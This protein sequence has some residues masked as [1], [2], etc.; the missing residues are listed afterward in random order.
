MKCKSMNSVILP[1]ICIFWIG[2][3]TVFLQF[4]HYDSQYRLLDPKHY[5]ADV[6]KQEDYKQLSSSKSGSVTL[7]NGKTVSGRTPAWYSDVLPKYKPVNDG[8][9]YVLVTVRGTAPFMHQWYS[10]VLPIFILCLLALFYGLRVN[11][12]KKDELNQPIEGTA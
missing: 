2:I 11:K 10:G 9:H 5:N 12:N 8:S 3:Q 4:L 6:V 7:S 1:C